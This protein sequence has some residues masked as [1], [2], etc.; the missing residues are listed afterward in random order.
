MHREDALDALA[1]TNLA[2]RNGFSQ[3]GILSGNDRALEG[4][5]T[6]L[7]AFSNFDVNADRVTWTKLRMWFGTGVLTDEF[8]NKCVLHVSSA[9]SLGSRSG[10]AAAVVFFEARRF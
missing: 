9:L 1:E 3:S 6:L 10:R 2:N 5:Q 4:L 7:V 8:G